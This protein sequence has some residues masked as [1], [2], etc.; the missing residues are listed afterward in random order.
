MLVLSEEASGRFN[1]K[2]RASSLPRH[3][4]SAKQRKRV[5][6]LTILLDSEMQVGA[7]GPT[8]LSY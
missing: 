8:T 4:S 5:D 1:A 2:G 7:G 6:G 3:G